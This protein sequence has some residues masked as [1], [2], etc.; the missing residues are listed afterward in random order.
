[1]YLSQAEGNVG[2][3]ASPG[4]QGVA[5][6]TDNKH[7]R[8]TRDGHLQSDSNLSRACREACKQHR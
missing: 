8:L 6:G 7:Q 1:M 2:E 3:Q 4:E 5:L